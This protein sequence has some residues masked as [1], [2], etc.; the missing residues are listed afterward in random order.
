MSKLVKLLYDMASL[1]AE[2]QRLHQDLFGLSR[3]RLLYLLRPKAGQAEVARIGQLNQRLQ[4][5]GEEMR[6][7]KPEDLS[8]RRG[9]ELREA[10]DNFRLAFAETLS[11]LDRLGQARFGP[12]PG[13]PPAPPPGSSPGPSS[14]PSAEESG[15]HGRGILAAYDDALQHQRRMGARVNEIIAYL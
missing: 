2:Y 3:R 14:G 11:Q 15:A 1:R 12:P 8:I 10:L 13:P 6:Q 9:E 4:D 5:L 7:L